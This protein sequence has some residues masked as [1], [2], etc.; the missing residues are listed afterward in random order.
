MSRFN[1]KVIEQGTGRT[2]MDLSI[3]SES[4][5]DAFKKAAPWMASGWVLV[6]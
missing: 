5:K 4:L 1:F 6:P 3:M 2:V